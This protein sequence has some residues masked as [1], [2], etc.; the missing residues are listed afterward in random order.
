[1]DFASRGDDIL[2]TTK[3]GFAIFSQSFPTE[4]LGANLPL[5]SEPEN[6]G[7]G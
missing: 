1:M 2:P 6:I 4:K 7:V 5:I 3:R